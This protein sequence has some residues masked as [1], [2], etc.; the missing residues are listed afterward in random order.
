MIV[1][2]HA[3][4][5]RAVGTGIAIAGSGDARSAPLTALSLPRY[6]GT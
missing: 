6:L 3:I 1:V 5:A 2:D 4:A